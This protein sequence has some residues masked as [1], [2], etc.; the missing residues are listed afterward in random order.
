MGFRAI[1]TIMIYFCVINNFVYINA[2]N[3]VFYSLYQ[4]NEQFIT[5]NNMGLDERARLNASERELVIFGA[6]SS[7]INI[8]NIIS[9]KM[10]LKTN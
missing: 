3:L 1:I 6:F 7:C 8:N 4:Q 2:S 9:E 10:T 5:R